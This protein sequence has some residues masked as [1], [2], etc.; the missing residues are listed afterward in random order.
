MNL[1]QDNAYK[2]ILETI[3]AQLSYLITIIIVFI[4][5]YVQIY[6]LL[7]K[8]I[9]QEIILKILETLV[10]SCSTFR[11]AIIPHLGVNQKRNIN[12]SSQI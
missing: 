10:I 1:M 5:N 12:L 7:M 4:F 2:R 11:D 9:C 8:Y 6:S 3:Q